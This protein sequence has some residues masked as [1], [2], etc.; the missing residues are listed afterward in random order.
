[1]KTVRQMLEMKGHDV[2]SIGPDQSMFEAMQLMATKNVGALL[3]L[4]AGT[5]LVGIF[6][7]RD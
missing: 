7:E 3:V 1:M 2:A 5:R 4:D 6:S